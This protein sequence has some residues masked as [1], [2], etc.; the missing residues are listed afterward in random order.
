LFSMVVC[1]GGCWG[2]GDLFFSLCFFFLYFSFFC[3]S[4]VYFLCP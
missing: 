1:S 3:L 4:F 2:K